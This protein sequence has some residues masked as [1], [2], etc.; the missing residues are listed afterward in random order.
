MLVP[1]IYYR[2]L[3]CMYFG[4][5][6]YLRDGIPLDPQLSS[7]FLLL[8]LGSMNSFRG[9][10]PHKSPFIFLFL[11]ALSTQMDNIH[12]YSAGL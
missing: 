6:N 3:Y 8:D 1:C 11:C 5:I 2:I 10:I 12:V 9:G 7:S 4:V